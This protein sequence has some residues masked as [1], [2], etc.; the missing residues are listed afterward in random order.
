VERTLPFKGRKKKRTLRDP[1][2]CKE[3]ID[4]KGISDKGERGRQDDLKGT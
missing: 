2:G 3:D 1:L 4:W